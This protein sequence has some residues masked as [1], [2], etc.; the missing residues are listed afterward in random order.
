MLPQSQIV[1]GSAACCFIAETSGKPSIL[2]LACFPQACYCSFTT[3]DKMTSRDSLGCVVRS[4]SLRSSSSLTCWHV[5]LQPE[6]I[7]SYMESIRE[8]LTETLHKYQERY[9]A[10]Q[11]VLCHDC[12]SVFLHCLTVK[13]C[14]LTPMCVSFF[15]VL[16]CFLL[17]TLMPLWPRCH[18][19][20]II[21]EDDSW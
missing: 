17:I 19:R 18:Y 13:C 15:S 20:L 7:R 3:D 9:G 14:W 5:L 12:H 8:V 4:A 1:I 11:Q 10:V 2:L 6:H 16:P 21:A